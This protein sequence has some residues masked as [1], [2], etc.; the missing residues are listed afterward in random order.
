[1]ANWLSR[2]RLGSARYK[3]RH[4]CSPVHLRSTT[5][6]V[7]E[8]LADYYTLQQY[9]SRNTIC[10]VTYLRTKA[11]FHLTMVMIMGNRFMRVIHSGHSSYWRTACTVKHRSAL[12][13]YIIVR[14][15]FVETHWCC[16]ARICA[17]DMLMKTSTAFAVSLRGRVTARLITR[18]SNPR[19][20][21]GP[22]SSLAAVVLMALV[23]SRYP[24]RACQRGYVRVTVWR[25]CHQIDCRATPLSNEFDD[26]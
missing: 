8:V 12:I 18:R 21:N 26:L 13:V 4:T 17:V 3:T 14:A 16:N 2:N 10:Y 19:F 6:G 5:R 22:L 25:H 7:N 1:M 11:D 15:E 20:I 9:N 23:R 24:L